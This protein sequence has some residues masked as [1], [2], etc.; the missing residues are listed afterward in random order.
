[1]LTSPVAQLVSR[2]TG[3]LKVG[4][5]RPVQDTS[6]INP[7]FA[8]FRWLSSWRMRRWLHAAK[9]RT[10]LSPSE[11]LPSSFKTWLPRFNAKPKINWMQNYNNL[12]IIKQATPTL[13]TPK[14]NHAKNSR[15]V[16]D[17][18]R[19]GGKATRYFC[20]VGTVIRWLL[21]LLLHILTF[22]WLAAISPPLG[23][24]TTAF[25][26]CSF[27]IYMLQKNC[28]ILEVS[29]NLYVRSL[30]LQALVNV[31]ITFWIFRW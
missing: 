6:K 2:W 31:N 23:D 12:W 18:V 24:L 21:L 1:M 17:R 29:R 16:C 15:C 7:I 22:R 5:S 4:G 10:R 8:G 20:I 9:T 30:H 3:D 25:L 28:L 14:R 26:V 27:V 13:R 11:I 19:E